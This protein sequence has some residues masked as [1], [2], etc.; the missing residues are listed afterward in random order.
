MLPLPKKLNMEII[1][2]INLTVD[3][4]LI[5]NEELKKVS[6]DAK[7]EQL[8][9]KIEYNEDKCIQR[10]TKKYDMFK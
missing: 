6:L 3:N 4:Q 2:K 7:K 8:K 5:L 9:Q 10:N 1:K